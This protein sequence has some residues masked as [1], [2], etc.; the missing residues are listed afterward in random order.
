MG[1][2]ADSPDIEPR[3]PHATRTLTG[4]P[5]G[6]QG[7]RPLGVRGG[8]RRGGTHELEPPQWDVNDTTIHDEPSVAFGEEKQS[9]LVRLDGARSFDEFTTFKWVSVSHGR[10]QFP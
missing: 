5:I 1:Q 8:P 6:G 4:A 3:M 7:R 2:L 9:G 10:R